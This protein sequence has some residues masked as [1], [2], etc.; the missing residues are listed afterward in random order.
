MQYYGKT[1][2]PARKPLVIKAAQILGVME[3]CLKE[4]LNEHLKGEFQPFDE[5][6]SV[7]ALLLWWEDGDLP[8]FKTEAEDVKELF[9]KSFNFSVETYSI[10]SKQAQLSLEAKIIHFILE[11]GSGGSLLIIHY[12]GHGDEDND[13]MRERER[14]SVWAAQSVGGPTLD[15]FL[16]QPKLRNSDADVLL[17]LD[18]CFGAQAARGREVPSRVE[19][20]SA[21]AMGVQAPPPGP[22]SFTT[23]LIRELKDAAKSPL[24]ITI[25]ELH[26]R[27]SQRSAGLLQTPF[28][29]DLGTGTRRSI[30]LKSSKLCSTVDTDDAVGP[31][32]TLRVTLRDIITKTSLPLI[33]QWLKHEAPP[34]V[35]RMTVEKVVSKTEKVQKFIFDDSRGRTALSIDSL[36]LPAKDEI[37]Q[38][39][40]AFAMLVAKAELIMSTDGSS[41]KDSMFRRES[42]ERADVAFVNELDIQL[43]ELMETIKET[44]MGTNKLFNKDYLLEVT[45][46]KLSDDLGL[47]NLLRMRLMALFP[48]TESDVIDERPETDEDSKSNSGLV[49][50]VPQSLPELGPVLVEYK[51]SSV[52]DTAVAKLSNQRVRQ[53]ADLLSVSKPEEFRALTC[54]KS[55]QLSDHSRYCL[56]FAIPEGCLGMPSSL[57]DIIYKSKASDRPS[58]G[59][60]FGIAFKIARAVANWH[61]VGWVHQS[62][63]SHNVIFFYTE[64]HKSRLDFL[65]PYLCGFEYARPNAAP[66][67]PRYVENFDIAVYCHPERQGLPSKQHRKRHDLYSLGVVLLEIGLWR[68]MSDLFP[69]SKRIRLTPAEMK[70]TLLRNARARL[71]HY[72]GTSYARAVITCLTGEFRVKLDDESESQL[73]SAFNKMVISALSRGVGID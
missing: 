56:A 29:V 50:L 18:C 70:D 27:L 45:Q 7:W 38:A 4:E 26:R 71:A 39:W 67:H 32:L 40:T 68:P 17:L 2:D 11:H 65:S 3:E 31:Q 66:S 46:N 69:T 19:L 16:I 49:S 60:R 51:G 15:W 6:Q 62:V 47:T 58:L 1:A 48:D 34:I 63:A 21:S 36:E 5:Y 35:S 64:Q 23:A 57:R 55:F 20:L 53:L 37:F 14:Q 25:L 9:T 24:G 52:G 44:V 33:V 72:M 22:K 30:R 59:Q 12:G 28:H 13:R 61:R 43:S 10:P 8:G 54:L 41:H 42:S 73:S